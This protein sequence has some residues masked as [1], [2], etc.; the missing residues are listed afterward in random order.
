MNLLVDVGNTKI[1]YA[2]F[3]GG[4]VERLDVA[5]VSTRIKEFDNIVISKVREHSE[6]DEIIQQAEHHNT[7]IIY[8]TVE[9]SKNGVTC[10]YENTK[11]LGI[12]R[13]LAV[14]GASSKFHHEDLVVVDAGT[15]M[16]VD[17]VSA[18]KKHLGGWII[19]GLALMKEAITTRAP[20]VFDGQVEQ[21]EKFGTDTPAALHL[22]CVNALV[23]AIER[24]QT[25]LWQE[26]RQQV[27]GEP[28]VVLTGGDADYLANHLDMTLVIQKDL[29]FIGLASFLPSI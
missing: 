13:W 6:I 25:I 23:G 9:A 18:Q 21:T 11:N 26:N 29:V 28:L 1:K 16:T 10:G 5:E 27:D 22:G 17:L 14:L 24:A 2:T 15:A 12:D 3:L 4:N 7:K 20:L 8:A 19:P